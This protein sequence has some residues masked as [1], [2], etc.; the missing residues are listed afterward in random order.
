M[1][2]ILLFFTAL[3]TV[4]CAKADIKL[5]QILGSRMVLQQKTQC[6]LWGKADPMEE[7]TVRASWDA[8]EKTVA[9][10]SGNWSV[11]IQTPKAGGPYY[12]DFNG[13]N[14]I[15]LND[16]LIGEVWLA[17]GSSNM[18]I[19]LTGW[20]P[21]DIIKD[22]RE[23][24]EK[25]RHEDIRITVIQQK[26]SFNHEDDA[27][28]RWYKCSP[29]GAEII[30]A[31][32]YLFGKKIHDEVN[33][34]V[35]IIQVDWTGSNTE[36]WADID[37]LRLIP[38]LKNQIAEFERCK[39]LQNHLYEWI[40][41]HKKI[42]YGKQDIMHPL[43]GAEFYDK[44]VSRLSFDDSRW[45]T[46]ELPCY[47]DNSDRLR[48]FDG[49]VWF[50]KWV[51]LP[52]EWHNKDLI[53]S[54]GP[55]DD[56]DVAFANGEKIGETLEE[57][58]WN[59]ERKY[60]I[61]QSVIRGND[62]LIAV[63][64]I[65]GGNGGGICGVKE[66]LCIY[67]EGDPS[68]PLSI[69]G[70]WK[71]LPTAEFYNGT[72]YSYDYKTLEYYKRPNVSVSLNMK[73]ISALYNCMIHPVIKYTVAGVIVSQGENNVG[74]S[75]EYMKLLPALADNWRKA[76]GNPNMKFYYTQMAPNGLQAE[77]G[78]IMREAQRRCQYLI[79]NSGMA[80]MMD[81]GRF[82]S[83]N[84]LDKKTVA[85]RLAAWA[86]N[87]LY[88]KQQEVCGPEFAS[89]TIMKDKIVLGFS[90]VGSGL[91]CKGKRLSDFEILDAKGNVYE[92]EAEIEGGKIVVRAP[93][94]KSPKN[95]RYAYKGWI[96]NLTL[97]NKEG[98]PASS[99]TTEKKLVDK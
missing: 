89:M 13:R 50:R 9:D 48:D 90:H 78:Q 2:K 27:S 99:F 29:D 28:C 96:E 72:Y 58:K 4:F 54:L 81:M 20:P 45:K 88:G 92:A 38:S 47:M 82:S 86:L 3:S 39:P 33:V 60:K 43:I 32:A 71:Y 66:S 8:E 55:V 97:Y 7:V 70:E 57:G 19:P 77:N 17:N 83:F 24:I 84:T 98:F 14:H 80:S 1:K 11:K 56:M 34:P 12:I 46:M 31:T 68:K 65:D 37:A 93:E 42:I 41:S 26:A 64:V 22:S 16:I 87:D 15:R 95:V 94:C 63:R 36:C 44:E 5:P 53:L 18:E 85:D 62:L 35:G 91:V 73:T 49:I 76:S 75:E 10:N 69:A 51:S 30:S 61:P 79:P 52:A 23:I 21:H 40:K 25:C 6:T 74:R 67:P 59:Y